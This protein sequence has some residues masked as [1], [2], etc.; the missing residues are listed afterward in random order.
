MIRPVDSLQEENQEPRQRRGFRI[1]TPNAKENIAMSHRF[2]RYSK[3]DLLG[4]LHVD[5]VLS[6]SDPELALGTNLWG[7]LRLLNA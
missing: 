5:Y 6:V 1:F 2:R 3:R 7:V 4:S